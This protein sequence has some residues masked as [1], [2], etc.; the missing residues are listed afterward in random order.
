MPQATVFDIAT[1]KPVTV[2]SI[3]QFAGDADFIGGK[4]GYTDQADGNLL[5]IFDY[6]GRPI[7]IMVLGVD[8]GVRFDATNE[9]YNWFKTDF[10]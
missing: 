8:D 7:F 5:S 4:T 6:E 9:V 2:M 3:N 1:N 10:K